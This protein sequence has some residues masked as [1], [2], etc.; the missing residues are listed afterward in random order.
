MELHYLYQSQMPGK[1]NLKE[2]EAAHLLWNVCKK[3]HGQDWLLPFVELN[4]KEQLEVVVE[5]AVVV[6]VN[7]LSVQN[8]SDL[9]L[10]SNQG[11]AVVEW[12][13]DEE[14]GKA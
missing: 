4:Q 12:I 6:R 5:V 13:C 11:Q 1:V 10:T 7:D 8:G 9:Q 2:E 3:M 14:Q